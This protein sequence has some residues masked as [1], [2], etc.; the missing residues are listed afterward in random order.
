MPHAGKPKFR[1]PEP[2]TVAP[3]ECDCLSYS[4]QTTGISSQW[5]KCD[6]A[7]VNKNKCLVQDQ[8]SIVQS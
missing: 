4:T 6:I 3:G 8:K 7:T 2:M 1:S 5:E